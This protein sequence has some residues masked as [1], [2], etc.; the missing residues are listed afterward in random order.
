MNFDNPFT[1]LGI[2]FILIGIALVLIPVLAKYISEADL[3]KIPWFILYV[4]R[5]D[6]F[7][8]VTS[9]LLIIIGLVFFVWSLL[10]R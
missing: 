7:V 5:S 8:F 10:H 1:F 4:Y 2:F 9:P 3:N 6:G